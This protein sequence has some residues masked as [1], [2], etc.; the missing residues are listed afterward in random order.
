MMCLIFSILKNIMKYLKYTVVFILIIFNTTIARVEIEFGE[1]LNY[2]TY[3]TLSLKF[4]VLK[5]GQPIPISSTQVVILE[6]FYPIKP[7]AVSNPDFSGF[8]TLNWISSSPNSEI[9]QIFVTV[10]DEVGKAI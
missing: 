3:P 2:G 8:Q 10:E 7:L 4:K 5:D 6:G 1:S 9:P